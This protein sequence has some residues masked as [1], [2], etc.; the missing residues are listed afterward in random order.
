MT[1]PTSTT[2]EIERI[3]RE[4]RDKICDIQQKRQDESFHITADTFRA[5]M[6]EDILTAANRISAMNHQG[7]K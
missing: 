4:C 5:M 2:E 3:A 7:P 6:L 1:T